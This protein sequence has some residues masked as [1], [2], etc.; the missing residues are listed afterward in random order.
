MRVLETRKTP[1]GFRRRRYEGADGVRFNTIEVPLPVW[2]SINK[3][4]RA[5]Q[6][7]QEWLRARQR[8]ALRARAVAL[9][10]SGWKPL[11]VAHELGAPVRSVQRWV[12]K[13]RR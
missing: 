9:V 3:A 6:R 8:E 4:G 13:A 10:E 7:A 12:Q 2:N 11:A 1:D 5:Q